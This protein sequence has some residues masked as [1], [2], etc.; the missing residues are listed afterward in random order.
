MYYDL[1]FGGHFG[2]L[3]EGVLL[4]LSDP[5]LPVQVEA[6]KA[7]QFLIQVP[8]TETSLLPVL[9]RIL[10]EYFRIMREIGNDDVLTALDII[11]EKFGDHIA[12][13][14]V[15]LVAN[16]C[17]AFGRYC[18]AADDEDMEAASA[19]SQSLE[20]ISTV[21]RVVQDDANIF[22]ACEP[23]LLPVISSV[24]DPSG[25]NVDNLE[26]GLDLLTFL[27]YFQAEFSPGLWSIFPMVVAAFNEFA[28]D[29]VGLMAVPLDN[30]IV[31]DFS[32]FCSGRTQAGDK[33]IDL[34]FGMVKKVVEAGEG[35]EESEV[36]KALG[37][38]LS[39]F[40]AASQR[41]ECE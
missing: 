29:F 28:F 11:V 30:F 33:Y 26:Y 27:T 17:G 21:L 9:P 22:R 7:L 20:C 31:K 19:A 16:L 6:G 1:P 13:H 18:E 36:R 23:H 37:L 34:L 3:V 38:F 40:H 8:G 5:C 15:A 39:V 12:P 10:D 25:D 41:P 35:V 4:R 14:A 2:S 32:A 24:L